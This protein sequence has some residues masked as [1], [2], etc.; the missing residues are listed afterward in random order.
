[1]DY[2]KKDSYPRREEIQSEDGLSLKKYKNKKN[3][4]FEIPFRH[5]NEKLLRSNT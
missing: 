1:M 2:S 3:L 4:S 5:S